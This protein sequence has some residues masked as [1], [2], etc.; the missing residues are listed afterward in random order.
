MQIKKNSVKIF[1]I[2]INISLSNIILESYYLQSVSEMPEP[3]R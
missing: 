1:N 2:P 3:D